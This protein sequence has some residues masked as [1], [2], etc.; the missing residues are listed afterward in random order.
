M[1]SGDEIIGTGLARG[2]HARGKLAAFGDGQKII[3]SQWCKDMFFNNPNIAHPGME[4]RSNIEW[5]NHYKG[6]RLYNKL[7]NG[8][9][10]WN[11][12]FKVKPG[13]F[14]F[15]EVEQS[16]IKSLKPSLGNNFVLI[17]PNVEWHK[18]VALNKDWGRENYELLAARLQKYGIKVVQFLHKNS[19]RRLPNVTTLEFPNF[20]RAI[21]ALSLATLYVGP[22][23]GMHHAAAAL[24]RRAVVIMGGF[25]PPQVVGYDHHVNLTGGVEACGSLN[26]CAHCKKAMENISV[27][28]V[29]EAAINE[30]W[31]YG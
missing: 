29:Y 2:F 6:A 23:G 10:H 1:G 12:D 4:S 31:R 8:H 16:V 20:R 19:R 25:I 21:A 11:Y 17:E 5:I 22:E 24:D 28:E 14:F 30:V 18:S 15:S 9:W 3:W 26:T 27:D 13:E 7:F